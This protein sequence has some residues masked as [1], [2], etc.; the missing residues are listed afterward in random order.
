L[1]TLN[2]AELF[3][4][5]AKSGEAEPRPKELEPEQ[6]EGRLRELES[7]QTGGEARRVGVQANWGR[8]SQ[9]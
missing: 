8:P 3:E 6:N 9:Q 1:S 2:V 5:G 7:K 4:D